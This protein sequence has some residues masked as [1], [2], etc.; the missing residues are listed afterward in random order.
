MRRKRVAS[1]V[2][3]APLVLI[4]DDSED[5][6]DLYEEYLAHAGMRVALA[7]DGDHAL[8]KITLLRPS[9]VVMDLALPVMDGWEATRRIKSDPKTSHIP[10]IA[11][12]GHVS[13]EN[14]QRASDAGADVVL[15]KPCTPEALTRVIRRL[16]A[17]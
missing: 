15:T 9:L 17:R 5:T 1:G 7:V 4:V 12:T 16:L 6:R 10:V 3:N 2:Q 8:W 14:L 13:D 11:L